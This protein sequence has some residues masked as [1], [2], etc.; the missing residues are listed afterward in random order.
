MFCVIGSGPASIAAAA[1][2]VERGREVT[3]LDAGRVI[4]PEREAVRARLGAQE[5]A[6]WSAD[7]VDFLRGGDQKTRH[8]NI[9]LKM[10]YGSDYPYGSAASEAVVADRDRQA[11]HYSLARGGLSNVWG[12]SLLPAHEKDITDWPVTLR[13][14]DPHYRAVLGFMPSTAIADEMETLLPRH[15]TRED[16]LRPSRQA[17]GFLHTL[18]R[19]HET[20]ARRGIHFGASRLAVAAAKDGPHECVYCG[21]CLYGC[22]YSLIYSAAQTLERFTRE[23]RVR[24]LRGESVEKIEPAPGGVVIHTLD[25]RGAPNTHRAERVFLGAG[26]LPTARIALHS[27]GAYHT[28]VPMLDSQYFIL[29]FFRFAKTEGVQ[30]E[31]LH[32]LAQA[33]LEMDDPRVSRRLVHVEVF[34]YSDFL[35]RALMET[36]LRFALRNRQLAD[37]LL[38]R[39]LVLQCFLHSDD[40]ARLTLELGRDP[41]G[42]PRLRVTPVPSRRAFWASV[43]AGAKL[44]ANALAL[45]GVP[46][47]PAMQFAAPGRSYHSGGSFPMREN[48]APLE[49]DIL[50][51]FPALD[52]LHLIDASVFPS[53]PATTITLTV[54]AN[55]HRIAAQATEL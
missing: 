14:L 10:T 32:S 28:P 38:G 7:D 21:L 18:R 25:S 8:G 9:H 55:A 43:K 51:R 19:H 46:V 11:F 22:P 27:L 12:A 3:I 16:P 49:T 50:G 5:P 41:A 37:Q 20:L 42:A 48:P 30:S 17:A 15:T 26:V 44:A 33:Y 40:S 6:S 29:P 45:G 23:G 24:Y 53:I 34:S 54:M 35:Q 2:L 1:A 4:E 13:D 36:P 39:L 31:A 47:V 52:R